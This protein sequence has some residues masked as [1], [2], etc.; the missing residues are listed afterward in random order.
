[1]LLRRLLGLRA[2][3]R[4]LLALLLGRGGV[5]LRLFVIALLVL[6][7]RVEVLVGS[8]LVMRR[9]VLVSLNRGMLRT[10][11]LS[12]SRHCLSFP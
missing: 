2:G 7:R 5:R 3:L 8:D 4:G 1:V 12:W 6:L 10:S 11:W 9:R